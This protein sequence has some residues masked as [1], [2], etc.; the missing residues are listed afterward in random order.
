MKEIYLSRQPIY[1][2][3][4]RVEDYQL[5]YH[6]I[7]S[8][9]VSD[10]VRLN[11][12]T[13]PESAALLMVAQLQ[14][15]ELAVIASSIGDQH[16]LEACQRIGFNYFQGRHFS[17]PRLQQLGLKQRDSN[18]MVGLLSVLDLVAQAPMPEVLA[19]LPLEEEINAALLRHEGTLGR[20]LACTLAY[21]QCDWAMLK[22]SGLDAEQ[23]NQAYMTAL[24]EAYRASSELLQD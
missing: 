1:D 5:S 19:T 18:F 22:E 14:Q 12:A 3:A 23:V 9:D 6:P 11:I 8:G 20:I 4:F 13:L 24:A 17:Q 10:Y 7:E 21:E 15:R 2:P 16:I